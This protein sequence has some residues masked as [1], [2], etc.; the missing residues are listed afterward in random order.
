V[1]VLL[2]TI[3]LSCASIEAVPE[4]YRRPAASP[5][6][7]VESSGDRVQ[8]LVLITWD[9]TRRDHLPVYGYPLNTT[10]NL[11]AWAEEA[12]VFD[13]HFSTAPWTKPAM[14]SVFT[15]LLP[16]EHGVVEWEHALAEDVWTLPLELQAT[17]MRTHAVVSHNAFRPQKNNF[18]LGFDVFDTS[19]FAGHNPSEIR[20]STAVADLAVEAL[21]SLDSFDAPFFL[22]VHFF[23]PH[24]DYLDH[25][26]HVFGSR[27]ID[28]YNG[29]IAH[30]D[31]QMAR[32]LAALRDR[33]DTAV[34]YL[35]D[36]G[37]EF[38]DHG[39]TEHT[40]TLYNELVRVP[41]IAKIPG[42]E[43][44]RVQRSTSHLE[45]APSILSWLDLEPVESFTGRA[46][47]IYDGQ[48]YL[49]TDDRV[50]SE[51]EKGADKRGLV[52]WPYKIIRD[53]DEDTWEMFDISQDPGEQT[54][55]AEVETETFALLKGIL[56][57]RYPPE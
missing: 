41:F 3:L 14:T 36:H 29:E 47:P 33:D 28:L 19:V 20:T 39:G 2:V 4:A 53:L 15:S 52:S 31:A 25:D 45:V 27:D 32:L 24:S 7:G 22:W 1:P 43:P 12:V 8:N 55:L 44:H 56:E 40:S 21:G 23:D 6:S 11:A 57:E 18:H 34:V 13:R 30:T 10:P 46:L 54:D 48:I 9:T 5:D 35:V 37:E 49:E 38:G 51:T 42:V 50:F 16:V 17:G 26:T